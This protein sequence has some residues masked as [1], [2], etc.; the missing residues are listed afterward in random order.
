MDDEQILKRDLF[1]EVA[2]QQANEGLVIVRNAA[3]ARWWLKWLARYLLDR[4]ASALAAL[5]GFAGVPQLLRHDRDTLVRTYLAGE[6]MHKAKPGDPDWF[7]R[8][9]SLLRRLHRAGVCHNDLAKEPNVLVLED[10]GPALIDFQLAWYSPRRSKLFRVAAREDIRH[11][12][13]HK[14]TYCREHLTS[15]ERDIL[16]NPTAISRTWAGLAKPVYLF[17]TRRLLGWQDRE[18]AGDRGARK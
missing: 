7:R 3:A 5:E 11:L 8:A 12:L 16:A 13:K 1:G 15:R 17:I 6:P 9:A 4:E 14:R 2:L 10:G 18:G